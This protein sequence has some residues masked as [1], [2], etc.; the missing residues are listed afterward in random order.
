MLK[1]MLNIMLIIVCK[2]FDL[3]KNEYLILHFDKN[4]CDCKWIEKPPKEINPVSILA[5]AFIGIFI[6][7]KKTQPLVT[8]NIPFNIPSPTGILFGNIEFIKLIIGLK[9]CKFM[10]ISNRVKHKAI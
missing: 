6:L 2:I 7:A 4:I 1:T 9:S 3:I 10:A 5:R 8:S